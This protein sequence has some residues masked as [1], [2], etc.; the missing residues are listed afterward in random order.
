MTIWY[1]LQR[2]LECVCHRAICPHKK[3]FS[4]ASV[5]LSFWKYC[6]HFSRHD[7]NSYGYW[8]AGKA[9]CEQSEEK[10]VLLQSTCRP[11]VGLHSVH[12]YHLLPP[13]PA[14]PLFPCPKNKTQ[15]KTWYWQF[16]RVTVKRRSIDL[17]L[18]RRHG[19]CDGSFRSSGALSMPTAV[20]WLCPICLPGFEWGS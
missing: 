16:S 15:N 19:D 11:V 20:K 12:L 4:V 9:A 14:Y 1:Y 5:S 13:C 18:D 6:F 2:L 8:H 10:Q 3:Q 17:G 7:M